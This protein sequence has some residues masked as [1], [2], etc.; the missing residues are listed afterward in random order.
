[1]AKVIRKNDKTEKKFLTALGFVPPI[2]RS[3]RQD[4]APRPRDPRGILADFKDV[5]VQY[6]IVKIR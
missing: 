4:L 5:F 1:M 2:F 3:A 6:F